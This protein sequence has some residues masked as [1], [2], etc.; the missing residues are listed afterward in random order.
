MLRWRGLKYYESVKPGLTCSGKE[1]RAA[2]SLSWESG[3]GV[4][5]MWQVDE[6]KA[7]GQNNASSK[8][9]NHLHC[10]EVTATSSC[11]LTGVQR[12]RQSVGVDARRWVEQ[13]HTWAYKILGLFPK[14]SGEPLR[15][16]FNQ[17]VTGPG[18]LTVASAWKRLLTSIGRHWVHCSG[19]GQ[20][21]SQQLG[22]EKWAERKRDYLRRV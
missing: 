13:D 2:W 1:G 17:R 21:W 19:S 18:R 7:R 11:Q 3:V 6:V 14:S 10:C 22:L 12:A 15:K 9:K 20:R 16:D 8:G 5:R 4:W